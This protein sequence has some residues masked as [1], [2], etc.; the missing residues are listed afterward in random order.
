MSE[1]V[2]HD[3]NP[4]RTGVL[5]SKLGSVLAIVPLGAWVTWHLWENL[6]SW[7]DPESR[8]ELWEEHVSRPGSPGASTLV[9]VLVF[10]PLILH[11]V[12]GLRRLRITQPNR[13]PFFGN[14]KYLLQR[15]TAVGLF[16]F[17]LAHVYL[18]RIK[19]ALGPRGYESFEDISAHMRHHPP[20]LAV[21]VLGVLGTAYHL[22]NGLYTASFIH[23]IAASPRAGR[24]MRVVS[25]AFFVL[26]L[27]FGFG[28][29]AGL[30]N[31]GAQYAPP[32]D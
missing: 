17:L 16:F 1:A 18:A 7:A 30:F 22:A 12:W 26:L 2:A 19:P 14:L 15:L 24:R 13:Y 8:A 25:V 6:W 4:P 5:T 9:S 3:Q 11:T 28:A 10:A 29:I 32:A 21:Y 31:A 27:A 20:T 23:G